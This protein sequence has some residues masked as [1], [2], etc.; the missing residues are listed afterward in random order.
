VED[1]KARGKINSSSTRGS[2]STIF[3]KEGRDGG[4]CQSYAARSLVQ[5][6][7]LNLGDWRNYTETPRSDHRA[8]A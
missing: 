3:R 4:L 7:F 8:I 1:V 5:T 2:Y 6:R